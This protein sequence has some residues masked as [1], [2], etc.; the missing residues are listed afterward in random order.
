MPYIFSN[1]NSIA[2]N[3]YFEFF[4]EFGYIL[5]KLY[6]KNKAKQ[7]FV[8]LPNTRSNEFFNTPHILPKFTNLHDIY[9]HNFGIS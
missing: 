6:Q 2:E 3:R 9:V 8:V 4:C 7:V 5:H 1:G